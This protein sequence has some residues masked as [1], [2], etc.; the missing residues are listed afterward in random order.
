MRAQECVA[1]AIQTQAVR[2][3]INTQARGINRFHERTI[4]PSSALRGKRA[5]WIRKI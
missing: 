4:D 3:N 1:D 5:D 2:S